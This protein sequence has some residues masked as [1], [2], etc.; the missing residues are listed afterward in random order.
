MVNCIN[1]LVT[2]IRD[3][4]TISLKGKDAKGNSVTQERANV[5]A[6]RALATLSLSAYGVVCFVC[7]PIVCITLMSTVS[8]ISIFVYDILKLQQNV[9]SAKKNEVPSFSWSDSYEIAKGAF[10][11]ILTGNDKIS[12]NANTKVAINHLTRD[13]VLQPVWFAIAMQKMKQKK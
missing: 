6:L 11:S 9:E 4:I 10:A 12:E 7:A 8:M 2:T 3:D 1:N 13:T 5:A